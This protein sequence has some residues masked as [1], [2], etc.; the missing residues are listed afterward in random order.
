LGN[1]VPPSGFG[2]GCWAAL[3]GIV[4]GDCAIEGDTDPCRVDQ[5]GPCAHAAVDSAELVGLAGGA[6]S[7][8]QEFTPAADGVQK[9]EEALLGPTPLGPWLLGLHER[10]CERRD[11]EGIYQK[12]EAAGV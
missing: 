5:P 1:E 8:R 11:V 9:S 4:A 12:P 3:P 10:Q 7:E 2:R 6:V